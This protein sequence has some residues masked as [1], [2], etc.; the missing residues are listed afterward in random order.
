MRR[1]ETFP[2]PSL[3]V[4][5]MSSSNCVGS[6]AEIWCAQKEPPGIV[7]SR[8]SAVASLMAP[9]AVSPIPKGMGMAV[10][11]RTILY[12]AVGDSMS[13]SVVVAVM[14][15]LVKAGPE[16]KHPG[17]SP[18]SVLTMQASILATSTDVYSARRKLGSLLLWPRRNSCSMPVSASVSVQRWGWKRGRMRLPRVIT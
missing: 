15:F 14:S 17:M 11:K 12:E 8:M 1:V 18:R 7:V 5:R 16:R 10:G 4:R 6:Y 3:L 9:F 2:R 13:V